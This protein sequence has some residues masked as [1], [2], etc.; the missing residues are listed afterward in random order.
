MMVFNMFNENLGLFDH[1][2]QNRVLGMGFP[3]VI[4][5]LAKCMGSPPMAKLL[6][7]SRFHNSIVGS[8]LMQRFV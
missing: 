6:A 8:I 7:G 2:I 1:T 3:S 4:N 5:T